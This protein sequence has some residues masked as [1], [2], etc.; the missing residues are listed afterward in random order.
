MG[1]AATLGFVYAM[2]ILLVVLLQRRLI[3]RGQTV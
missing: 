1:Y 2:I 3:G